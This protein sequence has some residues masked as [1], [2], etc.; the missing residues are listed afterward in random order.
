MPKTF[1]LVKDRFEYFKPKIHIELEN[2]DKSE[3]VTEFYIKGW[4][5]EPALM[6]ILHQALPKAEKLSYIK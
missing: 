4:K 3:T 6:K 2:P 5:I 1:I